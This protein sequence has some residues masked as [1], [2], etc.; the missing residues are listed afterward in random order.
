M[1]LQNM[2][3][4]LQGGVHVVGYH[5]NGDSHLPVNG[6]DQFVHFLSYDRIQARRVLG[7]E[8]FVSIVTV[9]DRATKRVVTGPDIHARGIAE[10]DS[11]FDE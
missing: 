11:V 5:D 2:F 7:E 6:I 1:K 3:C 8:G 10:D 9:I 4:V